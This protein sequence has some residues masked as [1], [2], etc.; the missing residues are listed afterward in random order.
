MSIIP[1]IKRL[2]K[3]TAVY[4]E[5]TGSDGYGYNTYSNAKEI[6]C[7]WSEEKELIKDNQ[8]KEIIS[9]ANVLTLIDLKEDGMLYWGNLNDLDSSQ[10]D[11]PKTVEG[12]YTIIR[13]TKVPDISGK[14]YKRKAFL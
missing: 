7:R 5:P 12:A 2:C 10:Q 8:G 9:N 6:K 3:H 14:N 4:W 11:D 13:F 1:Y